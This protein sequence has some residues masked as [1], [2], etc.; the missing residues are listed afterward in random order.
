MEVHHAILIW[1][2]EPR[3][4]IEISLGPGVSR[5]ELARVLLWAL[6]HLEGERRGLVPA[7]CLNASRDAG[8]RVTVQP[9]RQRARQP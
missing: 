4:E 3:S 6:I 7:A 2:P 9:V 1:M 8:A 5:E